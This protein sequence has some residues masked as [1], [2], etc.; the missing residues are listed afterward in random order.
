MVSCMKTIIIIPQMAGF[1][2]G[3]LGMWSAERWAPLDLRRRGQ[4]GPHDGELIVLHMIPKTQARSERYYV[5]RMEV[6]QGHTY[7]TRCGSTVAMAGLSKRYELRWIR[8]Q[9]DGGDSV[10]PM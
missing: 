9:E 6:I 5:G 3:V 10:W 2:K 4:L 1:Y 8:L 7:L